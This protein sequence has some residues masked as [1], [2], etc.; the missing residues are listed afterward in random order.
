[1][2]LDMKFPK[3]IA[4]FYQDNPKVNELHEFALKEK[5]RQ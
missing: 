3:E 4:I 5:D 1:M 2:E